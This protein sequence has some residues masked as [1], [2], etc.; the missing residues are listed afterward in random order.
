MAVTARRAVAV[1]W[2]LALLALFAGT[3]R[4]SAGDRGRADDASAACA[5]G[6]TPRDSAMLERCLALDPDDVGVL[7]DLAAAFEAAGSPERAEPLY[8]RALA[9]D[10]HDSD[11][12][13]RLGRI[14]LA[15]GD[16]AGARQEGEA[17]ARWQPGAA[18]PRR[19]VAAAGQGQ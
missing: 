8:R 6:A 10:P 7:A 19:L 5:G 18:A 14:L 16:R 1:L 15:R 13:V 12:R 3:F 2:P 17:A 9:I 11:V 4:Q